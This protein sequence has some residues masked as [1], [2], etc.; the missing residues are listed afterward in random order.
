MNLIEIVPAH[1][2]EHRRV[3]R[4]MTREPFLKG[5]M[6]M[7]PM[8]AALIEMAVGAVAG[9]FIVAVARLLVWRLTGL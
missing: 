4:E 6:P 7:N 3:I 5:A 9:L 1:S 2:R 8:T